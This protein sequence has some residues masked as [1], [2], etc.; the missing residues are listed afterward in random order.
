MSSFPRGLTLALWL[1]F[2]APAAVNA[3]SAGF[4]SGPSTPPPAV[5]PSGWAG[6]VPIATS[7]VAAAPQAAPANTGGY[8]SGFYS[9]PSAA[10]PAAPAY[11]APVAAAPMAAPAAPAAPAGGYSSGF[12]SGPPGGAASVA[13]PMAAAPMTVAPVGAPASTGGYTSGFYSGAYAV[14]RRR[15]RVEGRCGGGV[16][17]AHVDVYSGGL[18]HRLHG[19][20]SRARRCISLNNTPPPPTPTVRRPAVRIR[21]C[22]GVR[23]AGRRRADGR[24]FGH[25][26]P[27]VGWIQLRIL[28][29]PAGRRR[30]GRC[31]AGHRRA[32]DDVCCAGRPSLGRLQLGLLRGYVRAPVQSLMSR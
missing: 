8:S 15:G 18:Q 24:R 21:P 32:D 30:A 4:Y 31:R 17:T 9:G 25:C 5:K 28:R 22:A 20:F 13:A 26:R 29:W 6:S 1:F 3:Y 11:T 27:S 7:P 12:Y 2:A 14:A 16:Q 19:R 23:R 10:A